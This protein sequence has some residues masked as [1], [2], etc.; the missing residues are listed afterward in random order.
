MNEI[1]KHKFIE[2][3]DFNNVTWEIKTLFVGTFNPGCCEANE[4]TADW[5]YGRTQLNMFWNTVGFLYENNPMLGSNGNQE[6]FKK[7]CEK[8]GI[9]CTDLIKKIVNIDL[10]NVT[11]KNDLCAGFSDKKLENFIIAE[12]VLSTN[13]AEL[14]ANSPKLKNLKC[15]YLTRRT[16]N[17]PWNRLWNPIVNACNQRKIYTSKL[18]TPGGFNYFQF[19]TNFPRT[20]ENLAEIWIRNE[21]RNY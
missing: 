9:A 21:F 6:R 18:V 12:K 17:N 13:V 10:Q 16:A 8:H 15:V 11:D 4:N 19:N 20:A 1:W 2:D 7:F 3:L 14:I 5:F